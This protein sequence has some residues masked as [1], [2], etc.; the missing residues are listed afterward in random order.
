MVGA[1]PNGLAAALTLAREGVGVTVMEAE[2]RIGG[3]CRSEVDPASGVVTDPCAAVLPLALASPF[4][5]GLNGFPE[6]V[7]FLVPEIS[8]A[9]PLDGEDAVLAHRSLAETVA[10]LGPGGA[11]YG[12][13][14]G[15]VAAGGP[16]QRAW[17][18][19]DHRRPP[20]LHDVP[21]ALS[22]L[23]SVAA[24][25]RSWQSPR[26]RALLAGLAAHSMLRLEA[27][28]TS[29][30]AAF[31]GGLAHSSGWPVVAGGSGRLS[32]FLARRLA[33]LGGR[34]ELRRPVRSL[35]D[36]PPRRATLLDVEP[37]AAADL[38]GSRVAPSRLRSL[39]RFR[40]GP[41]ICKL[42]LVLSGPLPWRDPA[43][44]R[45]ATMHLG[46][47][48]EEIEYSESQVAGGVAPDRPFVIAVQPTVL[49]PER[50]PGG[51][52]LLH[53]YC[54]VPSGSD[55]DMGPRIEA[56]LERF[57][58]GYR[59]LV[60]QRRITTALGVQQSSRNCVG[61]DIGGGY[62]SLRQV[63]LG[64]RRAWNPYRTPLPATYLCSASVP[65][66]PGVHGRCGELAARSALRDVLGIRLG[67]SR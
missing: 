32:E 39:R 43:C 66:G 60:V 26:A 59:D 55:L 7:G 50:A 8:F 45:T 52:E 63:L 13:F 19:S 53:A 22:S 33:E 48:W 67:R 35:A 5:Q 9:H 14:V 57:A 24:V 47:T 62:Q 42:D 28:A 17:F 56:Q 21:L 34:I 36:L 44:R 23:R 58:P 1:G 27:P 49:D 61:G 15:R 64:P 29:G 51:A 30:F 25:G 12:A 10:G 4:F 18:L 6:Q 20:D 31:L 65:P 37:M 38:V 46:G 2:A 11:A 16:R 41:G 54:H 40:R 3:G